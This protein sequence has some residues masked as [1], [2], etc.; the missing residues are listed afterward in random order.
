MKENFGISTKEMVDTDRP[1][2][3]KLNYN[4]IKVDV[5]LK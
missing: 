5:D 2:P 4:G 1:T 3:N